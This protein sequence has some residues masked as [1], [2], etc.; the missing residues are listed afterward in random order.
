MDKAI[1]PE[2]KKYKQVKLY[3]DGGCANS[4]YAQGGCGIVIRQQCGDEL[5]RCNHRLNDFGCTNNIAE[6]KALIF[7]LQ[8]CRHFTNDVVRCYTDS[9]LIVK[10][11]NGQWKFKKDHLRALGGQ[12]IEAIQYFNAV[13]FKWVS[14]QTPSIQLADMLATQAIAGRKVSEYKYKQEV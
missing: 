11:M 8:A 14:R 1:N 12:V 10:Q 13:T 3:T 9:R 2:K 4:P 6:Y 5:Y 7:G